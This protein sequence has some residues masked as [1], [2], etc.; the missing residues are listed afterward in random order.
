[1]GKA[2]WVSA[3]CVFYR[4]PDGW[5]VPAE[6]EKGVRQLYKYLPVCKNPVQA[7]K[8]L[9]EIYEKLGLTGLA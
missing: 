7:C 3:S 2:K 8:K 6:I 5:F 4:H 9:E 1:M